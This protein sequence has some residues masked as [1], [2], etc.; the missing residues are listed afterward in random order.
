[1]TEE[2]D[3][4]A[5]L[6]NEAIA[7]WDRDCKEAYELGFFDMDC[8]A[9]VSKKIKENTQK[10]KPRKTYFTPQLVEQ[11]GCEIDALAKYHGGYDYGLPMWDANFI[12]SLAEALELQF[13]G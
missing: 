13:K 2:S 6:I 7:E 1:M 9:F 4:L 10:N 5:L 8:G 12:T 11:F 3:P